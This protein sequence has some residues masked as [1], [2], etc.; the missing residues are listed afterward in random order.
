MTPMVDLFFLL[1]T[2][3][4]LTATFRPTEP[5]QVDT[6]A[7]ISEKVTPEAD[8]IT[9]LISK[10]GKVFFNMDNGTDTSVHFRGN[11][12]KQMG[13][14]YRVNFTK[15]EIS[16]FEKLPAFGVPIK[17]MPRW[18]N[19]ENEDERKA[20]ETNGIPM[21]ST[22]NQLEMWIHFARLTN[23]NAEAA[24][25]GDFDAEYKVVKKI[26]DILQDKKI[27]KFNLTTTL[28]KVEVK[29]NEIE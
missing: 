20:Y 26:F 10:D 19:A 29:T 17:L 7:S 28:E 27:N 16:K 15:E 3:F 2:F 11:L 21:D 8:I 25:K 13:E 12:L 14:Y 22:D 4:M 18:I 23:P 6:P 5:V 9:L 24:I 1:L